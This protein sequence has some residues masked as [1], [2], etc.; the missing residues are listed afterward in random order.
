[1]IQPSQGLWSR[2][3]FARGTTTNSG[4]GCGG[5]AGGAAGRG[6]VAVGAPL[7]GTCWSVI[8]SARLPYW[9]AGAPWSRPWVVFSQ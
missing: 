4:G 1:M 8:D 5:S 7:R 2:R 3:G 6:T 9:A